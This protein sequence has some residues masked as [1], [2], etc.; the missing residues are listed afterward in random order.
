[1]IARIQGAR[2]VR[3]RPGS[4]EARP[5]SIRCRSAQSE[6]VRS[7][8]DLGEVVEVAA[9]LKLPVPTGLA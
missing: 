8:P 3:C 9:F 1:M 7:G 6:A 4:P 5:D 2:T